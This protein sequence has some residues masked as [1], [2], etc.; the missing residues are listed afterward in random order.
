MEKGQKQTL[1]K[2]LPV[3]LFCLGLILVVF[4]VFRKNPPKRPNMPLGESI[5]NYLK[6]D[7]KEPESMQDIIDGRTMWDPILME[8]YG[9]AAE[10][11]SY[12]DIYGVEHSLSGYIG[13]DVVVVLWATWCPPCRMEV[14]HLKELRNT[15]SEEELAILAISNEAQERVR[16][17]ADENGLNYTVIATQEPLPEPFRQVDGIPAS[18]YINKEGKIKLAVQGLIPFGEAQA[19]LKVGEEVT[20]K[21]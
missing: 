21:E 12:A 10:D 5:A 11:F 20:S 18:F 8:W 14:P 9:K 17:F 2:S 13:R 7:Q 16:R 3:Y 19:I 15:F 1:L 4:L 6:P